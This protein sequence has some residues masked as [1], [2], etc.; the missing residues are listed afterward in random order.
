MVPGWYG[1]WIGVLEIFIELG[2]I[3][4]GILLRASPSGCGSFA[5]YLPVSVATAAMRSGK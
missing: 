1:Y 3:I 5:L 2:K 4:L